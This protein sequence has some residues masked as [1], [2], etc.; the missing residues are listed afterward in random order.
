MRDGGSGECIAV[1]G[2]GGHRIAVLGLGIERA[3]VRWGT[4][5]LVS[6]DGGKGV[7]SSG[8]RG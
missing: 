5:A 4:G 8:D 7:V 3:G 2:C 6:G 1:G